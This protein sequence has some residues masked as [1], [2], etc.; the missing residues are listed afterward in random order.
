MNCPRCNNL[1][2]DNAKFCP[3]CGLAITGEFNAPT[4]IAANDNLN[5]TQSAQT[6]IVPMTS[7]PPADPLIGRVIEGKYEILAKLG[8]GGMGTVYRTKRL[9]IGDNVAIKILHQKFVT[10]SG[11]L[12]RFRREAQAAAMIH[13]PN[14]VAIYD[15]GEEPENGIPAFI[16]MELVSGEPLRDILSRERFLPYPRAVALM[17]QACAG[18]GA[19]HRQRIVHRDIKPDNF[20][21][22]PPHDEG[23]SET[24]KV[25]DF[26]IAKL[27][28][29]V[30]N[31]TL[32]QTGIVMG[33][34][35]YM[36]PEQCKGESLDSRSDVYSLGATLY[37]MLAGTPPF[38]ANTPT[39]IVAKHL[40]EAPP[41]FAQGLNIPPALE[42]VIQR[43][44]AKHPDAR[45]ADASA[46]AREMQAAVATGTLPP[47]YSTPAGGTAGWGSANMPSGAVAYPNTQPQN[48]AVMTNQATM[49]QTGG[50]GYQTIQQPAGN[51]KLIINLVALLV[52]LAAAGV[53]LWWVF[54]PKPEINPT[55]N[56]NA[57]STVDTAKS[58][59]SASQRD[60]INPSDINST[61]NKNGAINPANKNAGNTNASTKPPGE[62]PTVDDTQPDVGPPP[63]TPFSGNVSVAEKKILEGAALNSADI[64]GISAPKLRLLRNTVYARHGRRF[65]SADLQKYFNSKDW[66]EP[67]DDYQ[68]SRLTANDRKNVDL[69]VAAEKGRR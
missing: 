58:G 48:F 63:L 12:E 25:L 54:K 55:P 65:E 45:Q 59:N 1:L 44:L 35:Y 23:E 42:A 4:V 11:A 2:A 18:I 10:E 3:Q 67:R 49:A 21:V 27:R 26:G 20:I 52:F 14:V 64:E 30:G 60:V 39:G 68:D 40:T 31:A 19:A 43:A 22:L 50:Q 36:S 37:E 38:T 32:T 66:Y 62:L 47:V 41:P 61:A 16:V 34:P 5:A 53:A 69:L 6:L 33:T 29:M 28:D 8:E 13:H 46:F 51:K 24:L 15:A 56:S 57:G 7:A 17:Q 9:R